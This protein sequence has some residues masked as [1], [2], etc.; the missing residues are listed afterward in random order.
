L[1]I[2]VPVQEIRD[3]GADSLVV[4]VSCHPRELTP[5]RA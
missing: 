4:A 3:T 1:E 5:M 2:T